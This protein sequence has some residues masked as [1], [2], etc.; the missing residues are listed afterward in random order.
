MPEITVDFLLGPDL[1]S[2][3][4]AWFGQG[5]GGYSHAAS[6]LSDG[7][8]LDARSDILDGVPAGVHIRLPQSEKWIKRRRA[9]LEVT[10]QE[11]A[12]WE[13]SLRAKITDGYGRADILAFLDPNEKHLDG[14]WIC[15]ALALNAI[16][17][18]SRL[19]W[20]APHLGFV[21]YPLAIAAHQITP[22]LCML[23]LQAAGFT[24]HQEEVAA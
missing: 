18:V 21:P 12:D 9:T 4:I 8:Y 20:T 22:N 15:S 14:H 19:H 24:L 6:V 7:R 10:E 16:Q 5:K 11:Y 13:A 23:I 17:H 1:S 3:L 2:R